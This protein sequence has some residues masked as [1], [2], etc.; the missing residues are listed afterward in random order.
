VN[1]G[2]GEGHEQRPPTPDE[3]SEQKKSWQAH[4]RLDLMGVQSQGGADPSDDVQT[5]REPKD[6]EEE[7]H[8]FSLDRP[9]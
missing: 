3:Q 6:A 9:L 5:S 1:D 8:A 4:D 7:R 2:E